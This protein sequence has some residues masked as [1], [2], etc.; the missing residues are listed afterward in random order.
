MGGFSENNILGITGTRFGCTTEQFSSVKTMIFD[1]T[2]NVIH[3]GD[4]VG[5]DEEVDK[6]ARTLGIDRV[7]HPPEDGSL[8]SWCFGGEIKPAQPYL[9]RNQNIVTETELLLCVPSTVTE[10]IRSGTWFTVRF[11][12]SLG[13]PIIFVFPD[14]SIG[15]EG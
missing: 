2:P 3:H 6:I 15:R 12:R 9:I 13:R 11:A 4:C 14:G 1:L 8:R 5:V 7:I 10:E